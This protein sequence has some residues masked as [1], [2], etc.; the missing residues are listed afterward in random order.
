VCLTAT[1]AF[2]PSCQLIDRFQLRVPPYNNH[3]ARE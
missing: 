2:V 1:T 3:L